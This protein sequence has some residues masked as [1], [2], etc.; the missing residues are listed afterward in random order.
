MS[1]KWPELWKWVEISEYQ[2]FGET[3]G[4]NGLN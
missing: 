1:I 2:Y 4:E 3:K